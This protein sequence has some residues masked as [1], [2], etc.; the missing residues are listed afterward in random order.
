MS[1]NRYAKKKDL[2]HKDVVRFLELS[3]CYVVDIE[4]P[5]DLLCGLA[6]K[7]FTVEIKNP[8][9]RNREQ[10]IQTKHRDRCKIEGLP[11]FVIDRIADIP[12]VL[13]E[14]RGA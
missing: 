14:I 7:W 11:H 3:G 13:V 10:P 5:V 1:H 6:R 12:A 2:N 9:G 4:R 8:N